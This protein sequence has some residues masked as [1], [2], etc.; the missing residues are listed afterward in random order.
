MSTELALLLALA[1]WISVGPVLSVVMGRRGY[2]PAAWGILG[3]IL[4]PLALPLAL[5]TFWRRRDDEPSV[6]ATAPHRPGP[7]SVLVA[8]DGSAEARMALARAVALL[9]DRIGRLTLMHVASYEA[10]DDPDQLEVEEALA[11][12]WAA[13]A[14]S[15]APGLQ[16]DEYVVPG[17]PADALARF[18][19]ERGYDLLVVGS[20]GRGMSPRLFGSVARALAASSPVPVLIGGQGHPP[21]LA[22]GPVETTPASAP[23]PVRQ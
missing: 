12:R 3:A 21:A 20:R 10:A 14:R 17:R 22:V 13:A 2:S 18:A 4:G 5:D 11:R 23:V 16:A 19:A 1:G 7:S 6:L 8:I 9:G 15:A